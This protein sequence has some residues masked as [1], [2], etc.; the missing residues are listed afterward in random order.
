MSFL[1]NLL[2]A[3]RHSA[4][5]A[6][7][8]LQ[9]V[10]IHDRADLT[11]GLLEVLK[12]DLIAVVSQHVEIDRPSVQVTLTRERNQQRLLADIPLAP[13]RARRRPPA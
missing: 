8:R 13:A 6:K 3:R 1:Y 12:N 11:P 7:E 2:G 5:A 9:L 10:L 4:T